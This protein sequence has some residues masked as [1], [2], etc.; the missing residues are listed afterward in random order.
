MVIGRKVSPEGGLAMAGSGWMA[1]CTVIMGVFSLDIN[2]AS[3]IL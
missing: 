1:R 3:G 2:G